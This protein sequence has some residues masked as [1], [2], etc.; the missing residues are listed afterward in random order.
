MFDSSVWTRQAEIIRSVLEKA[1]S[2]DKDYRLP[3]EEFARR[4]DRVREMLKAEGYDCGIVYSDEH[5]CG[6]VP[7]LCG[8]N[9]IIV[10]PIAAVI[11]QTGLYFIAGL[12]SGIVAEQY[13][14]RSGVQIRRL[15]IFGMDGEQPEG[16]PS[17]ES[18]IEEACGKKPDRIALLTTAGVFPAAFY[19]RL[20]RYVGAGSLSDISQKYYRLK[21]EKSELEMRLIEESC[22]IADV[23]L[24]GM[25]RILRPGLSENQVAG[26]GH[27]IARELG[28]EGLGFDVMV[29]TGRNNKTMVGRPSNTVIREGDIVH[30]GVSPKRDGL[31]GAE[32]ISVQCVRSPELVSP[33]Y[34]LLMDFLEGAYRFSVEKFAEIA[35]KGLK[36]SEHEKAMIAYYR[37][38]AA[39]LE[40]AYGRS[41]PD[42]ESLKGYVT[43][44][45]SG[46]TEC[47]EF[48]G[49]LACDFDEDCAD[50]MVLMLDVGLKGY[51]DSWDQEAIAG[52]DYIVIEK[53]AG[54]FGKEVRILNKL[55]ANL[56]YLVGEAF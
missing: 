12:E 50:T 54:K 40:Q 24:E 48:Y 45:N 13:C 56:Q 39:Q 51:Y 20:E 27:L 28:A 17:P 37:E 49:A 32:R 36:G 18:I 34:K 3:P 6:D 42:F 55:P 10:E 8:N 25:L 47:Q 21:Y 53:T 33:E 15:N 35:E 4:Q 44:H 11:S 16:L 41:I 2:F 22:R 19:R 38:H 31:C 30:I 1:P 46:Y 43:S 29:T 5:Y 14:R 7:Y 26:W 23:M 52:L 9:N